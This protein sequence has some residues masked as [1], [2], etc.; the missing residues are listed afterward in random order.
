VIDPPP[1]TACSYPLEEVITAFPLSY[2]Y[3]GERVPVC[4]RYTTLPAKVVKKPSTTRKRV[5]DVRRRAL[6]PRQGLSHHLPRCY[7][8]K[9]QCEGSLRDAQPRLHNHHPQHLLSRSPRHA[10]LRR[11]RDGGRAGSHVG[12]AVSLGLQHGCSKRAGKRFPALSPCLRNTAV[13]R[14]FTSRRCWI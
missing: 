5:L 9:G 2:G 13:C 7:S 1:R 14:Y 4:G 11:R 10:G 8:V 12:R 3:A 6:L